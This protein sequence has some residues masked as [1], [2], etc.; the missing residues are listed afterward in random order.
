MIVV[1]I[2][3]NNSRNIYVK[4]KTHTHAEYSK[5]VLRY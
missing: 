3:D 2:K 1:E 4:N 5:T